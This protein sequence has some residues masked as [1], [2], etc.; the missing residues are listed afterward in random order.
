MLYP[1]KLFREFRHRR[2]ERRL[3]RELEVEIE[4]EITAGYN[5]ISRM[6]PDPFDLAEV[7]EFLNRVR[8]QTR[9]LH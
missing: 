7:V 6:Y 1:I 9:V 4:K 3:E 5:E 8:I 2:L